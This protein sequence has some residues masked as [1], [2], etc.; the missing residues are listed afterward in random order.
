VDAVPDPVVSVVF[1]TVDPTAPLAQTA[2]VAYFA[3]LDA[4]FPGGFDAGSQSTKDAELLSAP[5]GA[6]VVALHEGE[7]VDEGAPALACGGVQTIT[8]PDGV[9][10]GEIKRM[11]VS[12]AA[13]GLGLGSRLL[14]HLEELA[15]DLGHEVVRLDTND[16]LTEAI[17]LYRR[18]GY[19]EIE[20]YNDNPYARFFFEKRL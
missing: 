20:R 14:R 1:H 8:G 3:E 19:V 15:S 18:A 11:W 7:D 6:F 12:S 16:A 9:T 2:M 17:G 5:T 10:Y 13:R 4:R